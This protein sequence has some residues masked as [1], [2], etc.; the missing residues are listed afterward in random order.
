MSTKGEG[1]SV[2]KLN[3]NK[4]FDFKPHLPFRFLVQF[5]TGD[6]NS[7]NFRFY[8]QSVQLHTID[9][10]SGS[11]QISLGNSF[12][13]SIVY[14]VSSRG[15]EISFEETDRMEISNFVDEI[16]NK[17]FHGNPVPIGI[18]ITEYSSDMRRKIMEKL[19]ISILEGYSEPSFSREGNPNIASN[20]LTFIVMSEH[21]WNWSLVSS[22]G[23][24]Y[25]GKSGTEA[26]MEVVLD[27]L[28]ITGLS[29]D[30]SRIM[31]HLLASQKESEGISIVPDSV[32]SSWQKLKR[33]SEA[34]EQTDIQTVGTKYGMGKKIDSVGNFV[35]VTRDGDAIGESTNV[36]DLVIKYKQLDC[37]GYAL[38]VFKNA[39]VEFPRPEIA[40]AG[41]EGLV[42]QLMEIDSNIK[43]H[44]VDINNFSAMREGDV[45]NKKAMD[46]E[47]GH[48]MFFLREYDKDHIVVQDSSSI[49]GGV[50]ERIVKK[51][52]LSK[53]DHYST[54]SIFKG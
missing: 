15:L 6:I 39:G 32:R 26:S 43:K 37:S 1:C 40:G 13:N 2:N 22:L 51:S 5:F 3:V 36:N 45:L 53:Y 14:D 44:P 25:S 47:I 9:G 41:N 7:D 11:G 52:S 29:T 4:F 49:G 28:G 50:K 21:K 17:Q 42:K 18:L 46:G 54:N 10:D 34:K 16:Y 27:E 8:T 12:K 35:F 48:I 33:F 19:Y 20:S 31:K 38:L 23:R 30:V 24:L